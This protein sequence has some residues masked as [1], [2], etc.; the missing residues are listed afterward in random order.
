MMQQKSTH[1]SEFLAVLPR[2]ILFRLGNIYHTTSFC[3]AA[4]VC[5][6]LNNII[7]W[8]KGLRVCVCVCALRVFPGLGKCAWRDLGAD[9]R[10][11][12]SPQRTTPAKRSPARTFQKQ[13]VGGASYRRRIIRTTNARSLERKIN[14]SAINDVVRPI[15]CACSPNITGP[16][17]PRRLEGQLTSRKGTL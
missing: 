10:N 4:G 2:E 1:Y 3:L 14:E 12:F 9:N 8:T 15:F 17:H 5:C 13:N 11:Y 7:S 6:S 16:P